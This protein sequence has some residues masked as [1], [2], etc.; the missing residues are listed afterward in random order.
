MILLPSVEVEYSPVDIR[1]FLILIIIA[2]VLLYCYNVFVNEAERAEE[3][4]P[5]SRG[6]ARIDY[7]QDGRPRS[8]LDTSVRSFTKLRRPPA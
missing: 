7:S 6:A 1:L 2:T 3:T 8:H 4:R 5:F